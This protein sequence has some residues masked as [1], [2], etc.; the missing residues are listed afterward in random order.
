MALEV[1]HS[2]KDFDQSKEGSVCLALFGLFVWIMPAALAPSPL[3]S[4]PC[5]LTAMSTKST[6]LEQELLLSYSV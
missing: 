3:V 5:L 4:A 6:V 2:Q 1:N